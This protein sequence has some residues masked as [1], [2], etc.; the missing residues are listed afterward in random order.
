MGTQPSGTVTFLFTDIVGSS[1]LWDAYAEEMAVALARHDAIW[2]QVATQHRGYDF[3]RVGDGFCIAFDAAADA[4]NAA[5]S[6]QK[7]LAD[8]LW[9]TARPITVCMDGTT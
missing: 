1:A 2:E 7:A 6:G 4:L 5:V 3:K 8:V 9:G